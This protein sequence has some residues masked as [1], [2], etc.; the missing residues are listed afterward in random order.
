[1]L[2]GRRGLEPLWVRLKEPLYGLEEENTL[3]DRYRYTQAVGI[4]TA[5]QNAPRNED[6]FGSAP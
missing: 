5:E 4:G 6:I 2:T 1:M 3:H